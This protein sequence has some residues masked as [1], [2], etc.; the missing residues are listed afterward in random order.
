[1]SLFKFYCYTSIYNKTFLITTENPASSY[2][3]R[4]YQELVDW[5][6]MQGAD[7]DSIEKVNL[8][9]KK[10]SYAIITKVLISYVFDLYFR[11]LMKVT[12]FLIF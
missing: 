2:E 11:L 9:P 8:Y 6:Q 1:M 3:Q 4:T 7:A 12:N 10:Q 5:L